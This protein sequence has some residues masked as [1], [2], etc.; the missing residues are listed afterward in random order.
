MRYAAGLAFFC[1]S[2]IAGPVGPAS[3]HAAPADPLTAQ[4]DA[5]TKGFKG[6]LV[7][8]A[9]NLTTGKEFAREPDAPGPLSTSLS[10]PR[11]T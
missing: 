9:K 4:V 7:L 11:D 2:L 1:F 8:Y 3:I 5:L 6:T 10:P